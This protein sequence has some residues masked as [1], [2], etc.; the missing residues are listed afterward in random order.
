MEDLVSM[1]EE[2]KQFYGPEKSNF[3]PWLRQEELEKLPSELREIV[4]GKDGVELG[5]W[6]PLYR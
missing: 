3:P 6:T 2:F 4:S 5:G 1:H